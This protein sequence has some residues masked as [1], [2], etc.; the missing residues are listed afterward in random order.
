MVEKDN[1]TK[2]IQTDITV[3]RGLSGD[4]VSEVTQRKT[5]VSKV[6]GGGEGG[7]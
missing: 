3:H 5:T 2:P 7:G 4:I 6:E 1:H